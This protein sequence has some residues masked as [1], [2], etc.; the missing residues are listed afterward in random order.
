MLKELYIRKLFGRFDYDLVL[1]EGGVTILTGPNGYGKSTILKMIDAIAKHKLNFFADLPFAQI[2]LKFDKYGIDI[3]KDGEIIRFG[4]ISITCDEMKKIDGKIFDMVMEYLE[5]QGIDYDEF[6]EA[7][8]EVQ[9]E[10]FDDI[11]DYYDVKKYVDIQIILSFFV[12]K[13]KIISE[14]RLLSV[15]EEHLGE[16]KLVENITQKPQ[17]LKDEIDAVSNA[18]SEKSGEIDSGYLQRLFESD[19]ITAEQ[20][21]QCQKQVNEKFDKLERYNLMIDRQETP[22]F[23]PKHAA[24]LKVYFD[25][26]FEKYA[27]YDDFLE[28]LGMFTEIVNKRLLFKNMVISRERGFEIVDD[29]SGEPLALEKLSSGE[30]QVIVMY[31]DL[32]FNDNTNL[33]LLIDEPEISMHIVWQKQFMNDL[34][35][36]AKHGKFQAI[37]ATHSP[38]LIGQYR[39]LQIDLGEQY[40]G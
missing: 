24:A 31:Y 22:P 37:V 11:Y 39:E 12:G 26:F 17:M 25:T 7:P 15:E 21:E 3:K 19:D 36:I 9:A 34:V 18:F 6:I 38:Q 30:K 1:K 27:V 10:I 5:T 40:G 32:I 23:Q 33:L 14:Q 20:Y 35:R 29:T 4:N 8:A 28:K 16:A 2:T 13:T